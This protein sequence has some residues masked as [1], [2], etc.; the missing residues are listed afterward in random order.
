MV[1]HMLL[2]LVGG[3]LL[4]LILPHICNAATDLLNGDGGHAR[5]WIAFHDDGRARGL[6]YKQRDDELLL[7]E[8][9]ASLRRQASDGVAVKPTEWYQSLQ[10]AR[11]RVSDDLA[12]MRPDLAVRFAQAAGELNYGDVLYPAEARAV[13]RQ[14]LAAASPRHPTEDQIAALRIIRPG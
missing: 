4:L 3:C 11:C 7:R 5:R 6:S 13:D 2:V 10:I 1:A 14:V 12:A 8:A 9:L